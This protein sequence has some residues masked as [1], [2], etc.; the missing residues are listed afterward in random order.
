MKRTVR[1][2]TLICA[3]L[4]TAPALAQSSDD[5]A[6]GDLPKAPARVERL[7]IYGAGMCHTCE[8]RPHA[9]VM[10]AG[11]QCGTGNDGKANVAVFE[12]G[13]SPSCDPVCNFIRCGT[14]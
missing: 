6:A 4:A 8:W 10:S 7:D 11:D 12:C 9:K 3:L 1:L 13:R 2:A 5:A 14:E